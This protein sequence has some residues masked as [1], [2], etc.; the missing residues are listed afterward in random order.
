MAAKRDYYEVLGVTKDADLAAIKSAYKKL[1]VKL[2]PD[3]NPGDKEAEERF[4]EAAEAYA[5]LGDQEKRARYDRFGHAGVQG[6]GG[7]EGF[8]NFE[9][10][11]S[12]FG[13]IFG[14]DIFGRAGGGRGRGRSGPPRGQDLQIALTINL[15]EIAAGVSKK[16]KLKRYNRCAPCSGQGG[17]GKEPCRTCGG[18]GQVRQ[19]Q[20]S[21]FGQIVNVTACPECSG[22][23]TLIK[24]RC[25]SCQGQGRVL[26]EVT[27]TIE[28]PAGVEESNYLTLR[29]EGHA[30]PNGGPSGDLI[31]AIKEARDEFFERRGTD[32]YCQVEV[33]FTTVALGGDIRVQT[34]EG[35][36]DLKIPAGTQSE[37]L[38]RLRNK[39]LPDLNGHQRGSQYVKIHVHTPEGLS[40]RE[41]ELLRELEKIQSEKPKTI[42]Q[43]AKTFFT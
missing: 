26:D 19:V 23:G 42:F 17:T 10:I 14:G 8:S 41:I 18:A 29:G 43:K 35:E 34:L 39:G 13:D 38:M 31:V 4:K 7:P 5:V 22:S 36:V 25:T 32:L 16:V 2:H 27:L 15:Q 30:G 6:G 24:T 12:A 9:D 21:F 20:S 3:K 40:S 33:P 1:A 37:K 28:V 11:F